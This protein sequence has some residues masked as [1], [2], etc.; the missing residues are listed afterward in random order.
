[1]SAG[2]TVVDKQRGIRKPARQVAAELQRDRLVLT[3]VNHQ[4]GRGNSRQQFR[5]VH[6]L[7]RF[8]ERYHGVVRVFFG[9]RD[10]ARVGKRPAQHRSDR[11]IRQAAFG[12]QQRNERLA[13]PF[14]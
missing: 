14:A 7:D 3:S 8:D 4:R 9:S 5:Y 12:P 6:C 13:E 2:V 11:G 1:M 10:L